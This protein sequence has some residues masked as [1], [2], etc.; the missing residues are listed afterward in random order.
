MRFA[1]L[2]SVCTFMTQAANYSAQKLTVDSVDIVRLTDAAHAMEVSICPSVGNIAYDFTVNGKQILL[3]PNALLPE[4]KAKPAQSGIPFLAPWANRLDQDAYWANG[5]KYLLNPDAATLRRDQNGHPIHGLLLFSSAWQVVRVQADQQSAEVTS[6]LAF[7]KYPELMAQFPFAH[8]IEMTYRLAA[9]VLEVRTAI[10]NH[11]LEA[12]PLLI[13]FHPWYQIP[14][15]PRDEWTVHL[16]VRDHYTLSS[17][18]IPTGETKPVD[19]PDATPLSGRQLDDV[20]GGLKAEDEFW[21][22]AKGRKISVRFGPKFPVAVVYA[23]QG[24]NVV[25]FEPMTAITNAFNLA[26]SG[27]YQALQSIAP[28]ATWTESFWVHPTGF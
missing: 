24:R 9:G 21:V 20:Y 10:E 18:F 4:W 12:M 11:S 3:P 14:D 6:R 22:E 7:W 15:V 28:G 17:A 25:C 8:T 19:L 23:P 26:H 16:P 13:G 1:A 2:L 27:A 5:R